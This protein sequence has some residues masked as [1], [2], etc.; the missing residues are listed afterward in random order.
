MSYILQDPSTGNQYFSISGGVINPT[1]LDPSTEIGWIEITNESPYLLIFQAGSLQF[2]VPAWTGY[3][4]Q[5]PTN[6]GFPLPMSLT[7]VLLGTAANAP[8]SVC[9]VTVYNTNETPV[10]RI[11]YG[12][13]RQANIGNNVAV[14]NVNSLK[15]DGNAPGSQIVES[16]P[17]DQGVSAFNY[18]NDGS[19]TRQVLS[20]GAQRIVEQ[21][22][23]GNNTTGK[24]TIQVGDSGDPSITVVYG[25]I[26]GGRV[27]NVGAITG[28]GAN[29]LDGGAITTNGSGVMNSLKQL[30]FTAGLSASNKLIDLQQ[31]YGIYSDNAGTLGTTRNWW[32]GPDRGELQ[33]GPRTGTNWLDWLR[34]KATK[35]TIALGKNSSTNPLLF[36]VTGGPTQ[37]DGN[38]ISTDG[39]GS[40]TAKKLTANTSGLAVT[41]GATSLDNGNLTSDGVNGTL[42][43][44]GGQASAGAFGVP[45]IVALATQVH[46]TAT[47]YQTIV[48]FTT[49]A[50][51]FYRASGYLTWNNGSNTA[52]IFRVRFTD[53]N[54]GGP[55]LPFV[56]DD[57][58]QAISALAFTTPGPDSIGCL[59]ITFMA[60]TGTAIVIEYNDTSGTP[61]AFVSGMIERL[62]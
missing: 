39:A 60:A 61:S 54:A 49:T 8:S 2:P 37:L 7:P 45:V 14:S 5:S 35:V 33:L 23:R 31:A 11:P 26:M 17:S 42:T 19:G 28:V 40:L 13:V 27:A 43:K 50:T 4:I 55:A 9:V 3:P 25:S 44:V 15:N 18:N 12:L 53:P 30:L 34:M 47:G 1:P 46:V 22:A 51:G 20:A 59:P 57:T 56:R 29:S 52:V 38:T 36:E 48:S 41:A 32:D 16:T 58:V 10:Q 62:S 24:A 21:V 6:T